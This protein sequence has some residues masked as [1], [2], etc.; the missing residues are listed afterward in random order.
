MEQVVCL[1]N[2]YFLS[3]ALGVMGALPSRSPT[4]WKGTVETE[5]PAREQGWL[6][7][8]GAGT[9]EEGS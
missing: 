8:E 7:A 6:C 5:L 3:V 1:F 2:K 4:G 9:E